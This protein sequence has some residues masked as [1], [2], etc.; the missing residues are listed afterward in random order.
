VPLC[1]LLRST[2]AWEGEFDGVGGTFKNKIHRLIKS[3]KTSGHGIPGV[4][5]GYIGTVDDV[6]E[7]LQ[8]C[9]IEEATESRNRA[10]N[11]INKCQFFL[12]KT[13]EKP[14]HRPEEKF[15]KLKDITKYYQ[16]C[17][18]LVHIRQRSCWCMNCMCAM[19]EGSLRWPESKP[20][21]DARH[22]LYRQEFTNLSNKAARRQER[23]FA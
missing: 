2:W 16:F 13:S 8:H 19:M 12:H 18:G 14:I 3:S 11:P 21:T 15:I 22:Q 5:S 7:A 20:I 17:V 23:P 10:K 6:F 4:E 9:F 1:V